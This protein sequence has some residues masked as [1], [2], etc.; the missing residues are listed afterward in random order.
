LNG[1]R[2]FLASADNVNI[3]N[4]NINTT[5]KNIEDLLE[6]GSEDGLEEEVNIK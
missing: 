4:K 5:K 6:D 3:L 2:Q 1:T